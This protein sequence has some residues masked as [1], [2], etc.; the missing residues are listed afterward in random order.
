MHNDLSLLLNKELKVEFKEI[1]L[2][3]SFLIGIT[4]LGFFIGKKFNMNQKEVSTL[5]VYA[6][7]PLVIFVSVL[8]APVGKNYI[9]Y[10]VGSFL[11]CSM[12]A[13]M[14]LFVGKKIWKDK[15][16][17][18]FAFAGGTGNTGYFGLPLAL[19]MFDK[20]GAAIA[21][22]IIL[23]VNLYEFS[24]GYYITSLGEYSARESFFKIAKMPI[25]HMFFLAIFLRKFNITLNEIILTNLNNFK[26]AYSVLGMM[27]IGITLARFKNLK[28]DWR[29]LS[30][31]LFWKYICWPLIAI[32]LI[33]ILKTQLEPIEKSVIVLM[34]CVPMA[35]NTVV[36]ANDLD[37]HP[38]KAATTV[39][40]S[41]II[42]ILIVPIALSSLHFID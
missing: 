6:I 25:L 10:A 41:T 30:A 2:R 32:S 31:S 5:L 23:G 1:L 13:S 22:F 38:E 7:S 27:V 18:L 19:G 35:G 17:N 42:A 40:V 26:G 33:F 14:A 39:M 4:L 24:Y 29:F 3:V 12:S 37:V 21:V 28:I 36:I 8:Q 34:S 20:A 9:L 11:I 15:T 16:A